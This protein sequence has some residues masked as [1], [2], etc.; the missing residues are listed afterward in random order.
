MEVEVR[1]LSLP[2]REALEAAHGASASVREL[3]VI[4][5]VEDDGTEGWGECSAL[6][7]PGYTSEWAR[8]AFDI[9]VSGGSVDPDVHPMAA[10]AVE[11]ADLDVQLRRQNQSLA[12]WLEVTDTHVGAGA[13]VG[14]A[15]VPETIARCVALA[16]TGFRRIKLKIEPGY[17]LDVVGPV[18]KALAD[19]DVALHVD[20]NGS[21]DAGDDAPLH[22]LHEFGVTVIEQPYAPGTIEPLLNLIESGPALVIADE[23]IDTIADAQWHLENGLLG[24]ISIK[25]PRVGGLAN[26]R[27]L[28]QWCSTHNV[29]ASA[30]GMLESG[31]GRHALAAFAGQDAITVTGDLSPASRWLAVDPWPDLAMNEGRIAVPTAAG[32]APSPNLDLL[33]Q[34]TVQIATLR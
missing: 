16:E 26:A 15:S 13:T 34:V 27:K 6:T 10:S 2:L 21:Y 14:F 20:A 30:G 17:D 29:P 8:G 32:I 3:V 5:V 7:N 25:P 19:F 24:G 31:L 23:A 4:R 22:R 9:L 1:L 28:A 18:S 12:S 11:M 33:D